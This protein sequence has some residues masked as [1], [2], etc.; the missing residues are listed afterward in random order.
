[1]LLYSTV[2]ILVFTCTCL[3][4]L[5]FYVVFRFAP[6]PAQR[7][8]PSATCMLGHEGMSMHARARW[9]PR[10]GGPCTCRPADL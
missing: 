1:M 6:R 3:S 9:S 8:L 5:V 4:I 2:S 10:K 7:T